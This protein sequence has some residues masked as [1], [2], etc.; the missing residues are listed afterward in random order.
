MSLSAEGLA[1]SRAD[2]EKSTRSE[3]TRSEPTGS[4]LTEDERREVDELARRD[5]EVRA[6]EAAHKAAAGSLARGGASFTY[7]NGPD[8]RRYAVGGEVSIDAS[9]VGGDP[10][11]TAHKMERVRAA[12]LAPADPSGHDR[13]IAATAARQAQQAR[14]AATREAMGLESDATGTTAGPA[15]TE[16]AP[17]S[18]SCPVCGEGAHGPEQHSGEI[19]FRA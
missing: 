2:D 12:A 15:E 11:A 3:S 6:H 9:P 1:R 18:G 13:Q 10:A 5:R 8:G 19:D 16:E 4:E 14:V 17:V 7:E